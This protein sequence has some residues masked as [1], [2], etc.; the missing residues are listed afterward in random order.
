MIRRRIPILGS[1][2]C[3][4]AVGLV[5]IFAAFILI[6]VFAEGF[7]EQDRMG[8]IIISSVF[9]GVS[10]LLLLCYLLF[11]AVLDEEKIVV[12]RVVC[13][14]YTLRWDEVKE[15]E[16]FRYSFIRGIYISDFSAPGG[17]KLTMRSFRANK[18]MIFIWFSRRR[19]MIIRR[20]YKGEIKEFRR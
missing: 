4:V 12:K 15:V 10:L 18:K 19:L 9:I 14:D 11:A 16:V 5:L 3:I 1:V 20:F 6:A 13:K 7:T 2:F 17:A 8:L